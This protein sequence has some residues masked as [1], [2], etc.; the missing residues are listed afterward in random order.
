MNTKVTWEKCESQYA[1]GDHAVI[2]GKWK[3]GYVGWNSCLPKGDDRH[4]AASVMLP[5]LKTNLGNYKSEQKARAIVE[6]AIRH[7]FDALGD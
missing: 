6:Q 4:Y 2:G 7:W 1:N 3:V 5:G